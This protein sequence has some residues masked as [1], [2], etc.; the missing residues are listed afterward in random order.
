MIEN[1]SVIAD[2]AAV[3]EQSTDFHFPD[4]GRQL[5]AT[6]QAFAQANA[7]RAARQQQHHQEGDSV[8]VHSSGSGSSGGSDNQVSNIPSPTLKFF[9]LSL[10]ADGNVNVCNDQS[11]PIQLA[12]FFT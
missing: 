10:Y 5:L 1:W 11:K 7:V 8:S 2:F 4:L 3:C 12:I 9:V 6:E